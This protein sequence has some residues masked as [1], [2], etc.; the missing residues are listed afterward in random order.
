MINLDLTFRSDIPVHKVQAMGSDDMVILSMLASTQGD[1]MDDKGRIIDPKTE[2]VM[3]EKAKQ[4]RI[5]FLM[6]NRHGTPFE[7]GA[8][9]FWMRAPIKVYREFHR[10]RIG[11]SFNEES[12]RYSE[13]KPEFYIAER[14]RN[15][16]QEGKPGHYIFKPGSREQ[17]DEYVQQ[18]K[19]SNFDSY[20]RY[21]KLLDEG[22]AKEVARDCLPVNIY[23]SQWATANPRSIMAFLSLRTKYDPFWN[24]HP[25]WPGW[26]SQ[27][28]DGAQFPSNPMREIEMVAEQ[29]EEYFSEQWPM[30]H[31]AFCQFGRVC[32]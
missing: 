6:R 4:G 1:V 12:G 7:H 29:I 10:H 28:P 17:Y 21:Q 19:A 24:E 5:N 20:A 8:M 26:F 11:W 15:L 25:E 14:D 22:I 3:T 31:K 30:V 32:P 16:V 13:L 9:S 2:K 27:D 18:I 23:S